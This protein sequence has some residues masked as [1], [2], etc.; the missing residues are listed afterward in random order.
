M[1]LFINPL[2]YS[3]VHS[4]IYSLTYYD[5]LLCTHVCVLQKSTSSMVAL[6]SVSETLL[7]TPR[8]SS[9]RVHVWIPTSYLLAYFLTSESLESDAFDLMTSVKSY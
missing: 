1:Y 4:Y 6:R 7:Q 2:V 5:S 8:S 9:R 3:F